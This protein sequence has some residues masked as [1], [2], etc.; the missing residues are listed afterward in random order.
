MGLGMSINCQY[1][2]LLC[3]SIYISTYLSVCLSLF[4]SLLSLQDKLKRLIR[5]FNF[6]EM[7]KRASSQSRS[8]EEELQQGDYGEESCDMS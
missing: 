7:A 2:T 6:K 4:V 8:E 1:C 3:L 5:H